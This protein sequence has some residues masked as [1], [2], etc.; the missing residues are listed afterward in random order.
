LINSLHSYN[1]PRIKII[2]DKNFNLTIYE[3]ALE[4]LCGTEFDVEKL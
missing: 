4:G 2:M 3:D 1:H